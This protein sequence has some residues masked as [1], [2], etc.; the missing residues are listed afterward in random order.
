MA[1]QEALLLPT[2]VNGSR[3][4]AT[5][6][7][8]GVGVPGSFY[9]GICICR[10]DPNDLSVHISLGCENT[11]GILNNQPCMGQPE[12]KNSMDARLPLWK[13]TH[14]VAPQREGLIFQE[15]VWLRSHMTWQ[16]SILWQAKG[17]IQQLLAKGGLGQDATIACPSNAPHI[18]HTEAVLRIHRRHEHYGVGPLE[19]RSRFVWCPD[20]NVLAIHGAD[21]DGEN[22]PVLEALCNS[23]PVICGGH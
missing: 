17:P 23:P 8:A 7:A 9:T 15:D 10:T 13:R 5:Q 16:H 11:K 20:N 19:H 3:P 22:P 6:P 14:E 4:A 2:Q 1:S 21:R 18:H 12:I